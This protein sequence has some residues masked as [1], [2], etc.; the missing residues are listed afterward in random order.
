MSKSARSLLPTTSR[1]SSSTVRFLAK[2]D[3]AFVA[4]E[5]A[6]HLGLVRALGLVVAEGKEGVE[7]FA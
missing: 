2:G 4:Q 3:A 6:G 7:G 5:R 1:W